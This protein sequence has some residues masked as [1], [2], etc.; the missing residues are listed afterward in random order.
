[1]KTMET[2]EKTKLEEAGAFWIKTA[3]TGI[4]FLTGKVKSK[5]GEEIN[6]MVFKNKYKEEGSRQPDYRVYFDTNP[7]KN[8]DPILSPE[9][10]NTTSAKSSSIE[11][12]DKEE[13]QA[14]KEV[15]KE[16]KTEEIP[17]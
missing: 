17:F 7:P 5:T 14:K 1:M 9:R 15:K 8:N 4:Q 16:L 13:K 2:N 12:L 3:K 10:N 11:D 6:V